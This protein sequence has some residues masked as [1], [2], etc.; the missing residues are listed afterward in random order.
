[1]IIMIIPVNVQANNQN[2]SRNN[3][4]SATT[5]YRKENKKHR[6]LKEIFI[7]SL[8]LTI[9]MALVGDALMVAINGMNGGP[10]MP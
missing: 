7:L 2:V 9:S 1:M 4:S 6:N 3:S 10:P 5:I 8:E